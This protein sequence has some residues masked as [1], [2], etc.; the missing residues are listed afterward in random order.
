MDTR[1]DMRQRLKVSADDLAVVNDFLVSPDNPLIDPLL[2]LVESYGGVDEVNRRADEAGLLDNRLARLADEGSPFLDGLEWLMDR[3]DAGAFVTLPEYRRGILGDRADEIT[4]DDEHAVTLEISA[5]QYFPWLIAEAEQAISRRELMPGRYIRV[6]NMAEQTAPGEDMLA[7]AAAMQIIG[8]SHVETLD[9]KGID[10]SNV[11]LGG[12][13]TITGY[14]GGI[15]QPNDY[16]LKWADEYLRNLT[17]YG[18]RQVL[19]INSG[20]ILVAMLLHKLGVRNEFKV[21]VFMGVDNPFSVLWL[22]MGARLFASP[23]GTTGMAGLN[24][25]NSVDAGTIRRAAAVRKAFGLEQDVR[26]EHHITEA[27]KSI[28]RQPYLRRDELLDVAAD[29]PN[30]SAKHE[31]ADPDVDAVR[32]HPS[33]LFD[34]F[35]PKQQLLDAGLLPALEQNYLDKHEAVCR[36]AA[37]L[38]RAGIGVHCAALLHA[39]RDAEA[40]FSAA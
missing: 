8:A 1:D 7:V 21:S 40:A 11:H 38:T 14:F 31:G 5:L 12:P 19:N 23:E 28:V 9:T 30:I 10:G 27:Y 24:L 36:T 17:E 32:E 26:F 29:V 39:S 35:V 16:P 25:S 15:G 22:L 37:E 6:R 2:D 18:I 4:V 33:D 3:R 13:D 20:T 34:Y